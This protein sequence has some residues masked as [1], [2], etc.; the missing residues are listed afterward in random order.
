MNEARTN[1]LHRL[2]NSVVTP[3]PIPPSYTPWNKHAVEEPLAQFCRLM[4]A[5]H[6]E[7]VELGDRNW[8]EWINKELPRR[9]LRHIL[10]GDNEHGRALEKQADERLTI[11]RYSKPV[12]RWK[13]ELFTDI[14]VGVTGTR[15][16]IAAT[17]SLI[18]WPDASEPRLM[19]LVPPVHIALV[20]ADS[21]YPDLS[22]AMAKQE[23]SSGM[24]TNALLISGPSKTAD[25]EQTLAYG[26]HG[27]QQLIVLIL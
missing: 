23:W 16:A 24:P 10:A 5:V 11:C 4:R 14:E 6:T 13:Q 12:E 3:Q 21:I 17:G 20:E 19:S 2:R 27:P 8:I 26:I 22:T 9:G 15:G 25:I 1:I 18:L 7:V